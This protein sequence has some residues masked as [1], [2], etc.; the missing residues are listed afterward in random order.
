VHP[1]E[2]YKNDSGDGTPLYKDRL[3]ELGLLSLDKRRL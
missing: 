3:K 1:E 2:G